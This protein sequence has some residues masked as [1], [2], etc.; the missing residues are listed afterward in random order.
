MLKETMKLIYSS[1]A[2]EQTRAYTI[3]FYIRVM[4]S[5]SLCAALTRKSLRFPLPL[6]VTKKPGGRRY[7]VF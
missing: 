1:V 3:S 6:P 2:A 7:C 4:S 5:T